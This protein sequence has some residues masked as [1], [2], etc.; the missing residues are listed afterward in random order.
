MGFFAP[1]APHVSCPRELCTVEW[2]C[3]CLVWPDRGACPAAHQVLGSWLSTHLGLN[4]LCKPW[5]KIQ[6]RGVE[7][8]E[9]LTGVAVGWAR[10]EW[11]QPDVGTRLGQASGM[12]K[13]WHPEPSCCQ[14]GLGQGSRPLENI[15]L[16]RPE[17]ALWQ[18]HMMAGSLGQVL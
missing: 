11:S 6:C 7:E 15:A 14:V 3:L 17:E 5:C 16:M 8:M 4:L 18:L 9:K 1:V 12:W 10:E 2:S 13:D